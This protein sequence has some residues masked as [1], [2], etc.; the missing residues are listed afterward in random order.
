VINYDTFNKCHIAEEL[1]LRYDVAASCAIV[2]TTPCW[3]E[4]EAELPFC[5]PTFKE[6]EN[7]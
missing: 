2:V 6:K 1:F 5:S 4:T 3:T 7:K